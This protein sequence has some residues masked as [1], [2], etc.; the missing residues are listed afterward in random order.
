MP[1]PLA[2]RQK[3]AGEKRTLPFDFTSKL[4]DD[5]ALTGTATVTAATGLTADNV[6]RTGNIVTMQLS[7]GSAG[8]DYRVDCQCSTTSGDVL[9][10][11]VTIEVRADVN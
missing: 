5:D 6:V 1:S 11:S 7:S 4:A 10:L 9:R 2:T 3:Q 8:T